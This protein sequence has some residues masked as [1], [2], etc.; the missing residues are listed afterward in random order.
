MLKYYDSGK[1]SKVQADASKD[2]MG[3]VL[4]QLHDDEWH[5]VTFTSRSMTECEKRYAQIEKET[6]AI[7]FACERFHQFVYGKQFEVETH[8]K[9]LVTLF[10][11]P[12][13]DCPSIIQRF[14]IR[15]Q[16]YGADIKYL[17]GEYMY[18]EDMR[19]YV[20]SKVIGKSQGKD[21]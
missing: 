9:P 5:P 19:S 6:L 21:V 18:T 13:F 3:A 2:G 10:K 16:K 14:R 8:H 7:T 1:P 11:K 17:P 20:C 4:L 15:M 12:L